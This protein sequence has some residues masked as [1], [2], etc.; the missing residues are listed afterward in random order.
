MFKQT[1]SVNQALLSIG[2]DIILTLSALFLVDALCTRSSNFLGFYLGRQCVPLWSYFLILSVWGIGFLLGSM[3]N[4]RRL[5]WAVDEIQTLILSLGFSF[6]LV[7]GVLFFLDLS[8]PRLLFFLFFIIDF[9]FLMSWR[10]LFRLI[11]RR[12]PKLRSE[13]RVLIVGAGTSGKQ[14][15]KAFKRYGTQ[16]IRLVGYLDDKVVKSPNGL[17]IL[18]KLDDIRPIIKKCSIDDVIVALPLRSYERAIKLVCDVDDLPIRIR[19][20]PD[21]FNHT[22]HRIQVENF[23]GMPLVSLRDPALND[24]ELLMKRLFD[25]L[26]VGTTM[27]FLWPVFVIIVLAIR[28]DSR[29]P[30]FFKQRR[31]GDNGQFFYMYKFRSM[32]PDAA[33]RQYEVNTID[34]KGQIIHKKENDPRITKVGRILRRMSLDE[35]PQL[36]NIL[37]GDM[38]LVG[39]RPEMPWLVEKYEPWQRARFSVPQGL[40]GWWQV[41]GRSDKPMHLNTQ[42][43]LY[44]IENYS[45]WLDLSILL[46]TPLTV[47]RGKGAY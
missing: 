39:P 15:V 21:Y 24:V 40:T 26:I 9:I 7:T 31:V 25:I 1:K 34:K 43:D 46:R 47:V 18:G 19:V 3:Y 20:I 6:L 29:G 35:L 41:N 14:V 45:M 16:S 38:S 8:L 4:P 33:N 32:V 11:T 13:K 36:L 42:D 22:Y 28:I 10:L 17:P 30:V 23:G 27:L 2:L 5:N 12:Q 37:K 44:Y